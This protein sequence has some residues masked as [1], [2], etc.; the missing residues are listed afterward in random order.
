[1]AE[2]TEKA[3]RL[4]KGKNFAFVATLNRDGSTQ[5]TPTWVDTDGANVLVNTAVGRKKTINLTRDPRVTVG[6][7][8]QTNPYEYVSI[9]GK[10]AQ[11]VKGTEA[12]DHIDK[13]ALKYTGATK[14]RRTAPNE[15]RVILVIQPSKVI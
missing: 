4:L 9:T 7:F 1:L 2:L 11:Q 14:Y 5:L 8:E 3:K 10:V 15:E 12:D 6:V 13:L